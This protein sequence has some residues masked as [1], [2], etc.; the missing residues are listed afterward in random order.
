MTTELTEIEAT[1]D[2]LEEK[3]KLQKQFGRFDILFFLICALVG[4]DT[5][6]SVAKSG[7]QGFTWLVFLA[8]AFFVPYALLTAELGS[9]FP[10]E[11]GPYIWTRLAFGRFTA[12]QCVLMY[13]FSNPIWIGGTLTIT[14]MTAVDTFFGTMSST[15]KYAV[16]FLYICLCIASTNLSV[17][18][19]KWVTAVGAWAR[20]VLLS[21]FTGSVILYAVRNGLH[22]FHGHDF[23]PSYAAFI[24]VVPVLVFNY[25]GFEIPSSAGDEMRN[26]KRDV[27]IAIA[28]SAI[29][30]VLLYGV[31]ILCVLLVLPQSNVTGLSGF[32]DAVKAV[33]TVYG[34]SIAADGKVTLTGMGSIMGEVAAIGFIL[35]TATSAAAWL[36][37]ANRALAV[38][39]YDGAAPRWLG[40]FS[41]QSGT[42]VVANVV[43]GILSVVVMI[44][45]YRLT[46]NPNQYFSA[47]LG[48]AVATTTI[49]YLF[50][51]PTVIK[52]RLSRG[53]TERPYRIPRG[54]L[55]VWICGLTATFW[56]FV[57]TVGQIWPGIGVNWFG[58]TVNPDD[59]LPTGFASLRFKYEMTQIVPLLVLFALGV[60]FYAMGRPTRRRQIEADIP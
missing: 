33:F 30:A 13:W 37:G 26:P 25:V 49:S 32:V 19:G 16:S 2:A 51:F 17:R 59:S 21:L 3:R 45:S 5:I 6:G 52:L 18:Y 23:L 46:V 48:L 43:S 15:V 4:L 60:L 28:R 20:V 55:G 29:G 56:T 14:S 34:G 24:T 10:E 22:G 8:V 12:A 40:H 31:P 9:A 50:I 58:Q 39:A 44:V 36:M 42:P 7:A 11:G 53:D 41:A 27:P 38:A 57:A 35:G 1:P 47:V 54:M